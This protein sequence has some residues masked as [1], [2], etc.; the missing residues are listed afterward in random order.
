MPVLKTPYPVL[1]VPP[2]IYDYKYMDL[3]ANALRF[4]HNEVR[5]PGELRGTTLTLTEL[6]T[7]GVGLEAGSIIV[8]PGTR[9]LS[10]VLINEAW[11]D[12]LQAVGQV[13]NVTVSV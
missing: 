11:T 5:N 7:S 6:P 4:F 3:L 12:G 13:G 8:V 2:K 9:Y 1:P 10:I